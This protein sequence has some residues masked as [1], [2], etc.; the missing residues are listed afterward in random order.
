MSERGIG[1]IIGQRLAKK[2]QRV[3]YKRYYPIGYGLISSYQDK[4]NWGSY[5]YWQ[6]YTVDLN[7]I[8]LE[9]NYQIQKEI[10]RCRRMNGD[11][12]DVGKNLKRR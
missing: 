5:F 4:T 3:P 10:N 9:N 2:K 11:A 1:A 12:P 8:H 7:R 6:T